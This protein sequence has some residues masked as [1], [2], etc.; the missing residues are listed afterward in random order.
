MNWFRGLTQRYA[1]LRRAPRMLRRRRVPL[2]LI[3]TVLVFALTQTDRFAAFIPLQ[4]AE[5]AITDWRFRVRGNRPGNP[6]V[7][8]VGITGSSLD[9]TLLDEFASEHEGVALMQKPWPWNRRFWAL[10]IDRLFQLGARTVALDILLPGEREGN[11]ELAEVIAKYPGRVVL[12]STMIIENNEG[13]RRSQ[14]FIVPDESIIGDRRSELV[15]YCFLPPDSDNVIRRVSYRTS[16]IREFRGR[17]DTQDLTSFAAFAVQKF[18]GQ[19]APYGYDQPINYQGPATTYPYIPVEQVFVDRL[20]AQLPPAQ[21]EAPFRDKLVFV[22][23]IAETF[24]DVHKTPFG[25]DAETTPGVEIHAQIAGALLA[26]I[27]L[28]DAP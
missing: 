9:P 25:R 22:G 13:L 16:E 23:P 21:R 18:T 15:G 27:P 12:G 19:A 20:L 8:I 1:W 24:H 2:V 3:W 5:Q 6:A 11:A 17:D 10:L 26:G 4:K 7:T 28:R 14:T